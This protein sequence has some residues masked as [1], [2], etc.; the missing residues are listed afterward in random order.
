MYAIG[1]RGKSLERSAQGPSPSP[2][3]TS[4]RIRDPGGLEQFGHQKPQELH[5]YPISRPADP[6]LTL[7]QITV[8]N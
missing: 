6:L 8:R 2:P 5:I 3:D 1:G 4:P 7:H